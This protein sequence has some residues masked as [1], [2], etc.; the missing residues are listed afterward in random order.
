MKTVV[1]YISEYGFGHA[2]RCIALM[3]EMLQTRKDIQIIVCHSFALQFIRESLKKYEDKIIFHDVE[4]DIGYILKEHSLELD[5][6]KLQL[7][8]E[9]FCEKL[10]EKINNEVSFLS[11]FQVDCI[12]SD[13]SPIA[14]EIAEKL[15]V[16]SIGIS[17]FTWYTAYKNIFS[18]DMLKLFY[19]MYKKMDYFYALAGS[20]E[21]QWAKTETFYFNFYSRKAQLSEVRNIRQELDPTGKKKLI[22]VPLGM[23]INV[24]DITKFPLWDRKHCVFIVSS[25]MNIEHCNVYKIPMDYTESQN[26]VAASDCVISKAGWGTVSEAVVHRKPLVIIDRK[27][28]SE[29]QN[30]IHFLRDNNLCE[31][32]TWEKVATMN[33]CDYIS[34]RQAIY[35]NEV[36]DIV[37]HIFRTINKNGINTIQKE[38]IIQR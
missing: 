1:F 25:N 30:T 32:T 9:E 4:T 2:A 24:G 14:F 13:I 26:Y 10:L 29:D 20:K 35:Q 11:S 17:N 8:Y 15:E 16:P 5:V 38:G 18:K 33:P 31:L 3:R 21:K 34:R 27:G 36:L 37:S 28:M 12:V 19:K 7:A 22:F 6:E 23:K